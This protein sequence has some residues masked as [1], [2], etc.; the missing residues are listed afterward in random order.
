MLLFS[1]YDKKIMKLSRKKPFPNSGVARRVRTLGRLELTL[2]V[3]TIHPSSLEFNACQLMWKKT[4]THR[5]CLSGYQLTNPA[6]RVV[7]HALYGRKPAP[8]LCCL[9][10]KLWISKSKTVPKMRVF[11]PH[12]FSRYTIHIARCLWD[13][14]YST[15][16]HIVLQISRMY[17]HRRP[18]IG[19]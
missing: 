1:I 9:S 4:K 16:V 3:N 11:A 13:I 14:F 8:C 17:V 19:L 6:V 15:Y 5:L 2:V 18:T 7:M 10:R 12:F